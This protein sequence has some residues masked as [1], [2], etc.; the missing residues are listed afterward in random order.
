M[1]S[2]SAELHVAGF[3]F[4][5][6]HCHFGV[7]QATHQRGRVSTR[8]RHEP[9][10][11]TLSVPDEGA[12][13]AWAA[14]AQKRQAAAVV[15]R[16]ANGGSPVETLALGAAYCVNYQE[17]FVSG[18]ATNGAYVCHLVLSDPDGFTI[19]AGGPATAFVAPAAREHGVPGAALVGAAIGGVVG[20][21]AQKLPIIPLTEDISPAAWDGRKELPPYTE[22]HKEARWA[23]YQRDHANDT[24][25]YSQARWNNSYETTR[26]NNI[27]GLGREREYAAAMGAESRVLKT[28]FT[29]RQ[30]DMYIE[31]TG[32]CGQLK[33]GPLYLREKEKTDLKKDADLVMKGFEVEYILEK[34]A[35]KPMLAAIEAAGGTYRIGPQIS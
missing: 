28:A 25:A 29:F 34:G 3:R 7:H 32:Y 10:H 8:V 5:V 21:S 1:A 12:L 19:Q 27:F 11:L 26:N 33:T 13:L 15:F 18:D 2:F 17:E 4:P 16:D 23:E 35:S 30:I 20:G 31:K 6:L 24:K 14:E 9:V 22:E